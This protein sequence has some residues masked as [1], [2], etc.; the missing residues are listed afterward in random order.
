LNHQAEKKEKLFPENGHQKDKEYRSNSMMRGDNKKTNWLKHLMGEDLNGH[1]K[2]L[3]VFTIRLLYYVNGLVSTGN[4]NSLHNI[5]K[6]FI[7]N[8][9]KC[10]LFY[11]QTKK[12]CG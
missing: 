9:K 4:I 2:S 12:N 3:T 5:K 10:K 8:E 1:K 11:S 7:T 6:N